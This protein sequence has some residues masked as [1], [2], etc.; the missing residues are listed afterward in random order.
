[1]A[2]RYISP[3]TQHFNKSTGEPLA[4]GLLYFY[5]AGATSTPKTTYT[6]SGEGTANTN[7]VVLDNKGFEPSIWGTGSYSVVL[8]SKSGEDINQWSRDPIDF[9]SS[10]SVGFGNWLSTVDY[11]VNDIAEDT[12]GN[13]YISIQTPNVNKDPS[14]TATYWSRIQFMETWNTNKSYS[15]GD[16]VA[17]NNRFYTAKVAQTGNTPVSDA[18]T[19]WQ[20]ST[21]FRGCLVETGANDSQ[22]TTASSVVYDGW[23]VEA[24][25][26]DAIHDNSSNPERL[27]VPTGVTYVRIS[28]ALATVDAGSST[29]FIIMELFKNGVKTFVGYEQRTT[30]Y[31]NQGVLSIVSP[32]M[33]VTAGDYFDLRV[34]DTTD[35]TSSVFSYSGTAVVG[36]FAM[37]IMQ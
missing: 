10:T 16:I 30:T 19:N 33:L 11:A 31:V 14:S 29:G 6:D 37:E 7:P 15:I 36:N 23:D 17:L 28:G 9:N 26:T 4:G 25:D 21:E 18:S 24:Y 32:I 22:T 13:F 2:S 34:R 5:E 20:R 12:D 3:T 35:G 1:M 27:T 8:T